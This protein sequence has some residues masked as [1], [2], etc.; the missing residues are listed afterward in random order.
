MRD[1]N[2]FVTS[3]TS[4]ELFGQLLAQLAQLP[5]VSVAS[6]VCL[7]LSDSPADA[8]ITGAP[9][10]PP[11]ELD[12]SV[13]MAK[14]ELLR[15][16]QLGFSWVSSGPA[17]P[18]IARIITEL[19]ELGCFIFCAIVP[20]ADRREDMTVYWSKPQPTGELSELAAS[21]SNQAVLLMDAEISAEWLD[22]SAEDR[23]VPFELARFD[24]DALSVR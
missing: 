7:G 6:Q 2:C 5:G 19:S 14:Q 24:P 22:A 1:A 4:E 9:D 15:V 16:G 12:A 21:E 3:K 20:D 18:Q 11:R 17:R 23:A 10:M 13:L 8:A